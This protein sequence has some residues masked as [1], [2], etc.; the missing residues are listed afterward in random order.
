[1]TVI[2]EIKSALEQKGL[3]ERAVWL[4]ILSGGRWLEKTKSVKFP[5]LG[6]DCNLYLV[7][8]DM[9][10]NREIAQIAKIKDSQKWNSWNDFLKKLRNQILEENVVAGI[11]SCDSLR[12]IV[13]DQLVCWAQIMGALLSID[14]KTAQIR[15]FLGAVTKLETDLQPYK[16]EEYRLFKSLS[17]LCRRTA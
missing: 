7:P 2:D 15:K 13:P 4:K 10:I 11:N 6:N 16:P 14:L 8:F 5:D 9:N 12:N 3:V 17:G 1:M